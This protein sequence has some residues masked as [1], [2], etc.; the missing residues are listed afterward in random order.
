MKRVIAF[1]FGLLIPIVACSASD[2]AAISSALN[3]GEKDLRAVC[4]ELP[5]VD[6]GH[7]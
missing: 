1:A 6:A 7:D 4:A 2:Q 5:P 3:K